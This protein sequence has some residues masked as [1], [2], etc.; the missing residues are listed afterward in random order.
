MKLFFL[1]RVAIVFATFFF[2]FSC[3]NEFK[4]DP[5]GKINTDRLPETQKEK[6]TVTIIK[7]VGEILKKVY[8]DP[9]AYFEVNAT[10]YSNYYEDERVLLKD[11][12]F[13][14]TSTLYK[15]EKFKSLKVEPGFFKKKFLETL[16][17]G[18]YTELKKAMGMGISQSNS[19]AASAAAS[20]PTDTAAEI[21]S[22]SSGTAIY[23]PYS[24]NF[25]S[26]FTASYFDAINSPDNRYR[27]L[28]TIVSSQA[29]ADSGP[30]GEPYV[31]GTKLNPTLC[32]RNLTVND[33]YAE[34]HQTHIVGV[35]AQQRPLDPPPP[36]T[37]VPNVN[38]VY[39]GWS[40]L[41]TQLDRLISFTG[42]GG[43]SEMKIARIS[44]YLQFQDQ[45]VVNFTGDVV[46]A[47]FTR[48][49]IRKKRWKRVYSVW[50][51]DWV[52]NNLEQIYAIWEDDN[53]GTKTFTGSVT[54]TVSTGN[55]A[56]IGF[57]I[58]VMT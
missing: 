6:E 7:Q 16:N 30:G 58:N 55:S 9:K 38:R 19:K 32:W 56:T 13:P 35:G 53:K 43:G 50:D 36:P 34:I 21:F 27:Y 18:E 22:N 31:C 46:T 26:N 37:P 39:H 41:T 2:L 42:N 12:L 49:E 15:S 25:G 40:R 52:S 8:N 33:D 4:N 24:E 1:R 51:A 28:A 5:P 20:I 10:I 47:Q 45:Q 57:S 11:L 44:G 23:F 29:D 48:K 54:T 3:Q 17:A 14:E